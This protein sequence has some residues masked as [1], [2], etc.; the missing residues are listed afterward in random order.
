MN[1]EK[2]INYE[3]ENL[4]LNEDFKTLKECF[5]EG[6]DSY[7]LEQKAQFKTYIEHLMNGKI[8]PRKK[9]KFK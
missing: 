1:D 3:N 9:R 8:S 4:E 7:T 2:N 6:K 5:N